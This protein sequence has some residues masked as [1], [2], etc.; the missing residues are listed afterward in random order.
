[1]NEHPRDTVVVNGQERPAIRMDVVSV[2]EPWT[3]ILLVGG[4]V[5]R[6][7]LVIVSVHYVPSLSVPGRPFFSIASGL[8][9][10]VRP[11]AHVHGGS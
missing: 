11:N 9:F 4:T 6:Q 5:L 8:V 3:E 2:Q 10:E 1:M 7:R